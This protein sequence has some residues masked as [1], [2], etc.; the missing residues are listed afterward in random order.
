VVGLLLAL[1]APALGQERK[2]LPE[3]AFGPKP[4]RNPD[5]T[6]SVNKFLS[7]T[8][9]DLQG[10]GIYSRYNF[11]DIKRPYDGLDV[12]SELKLSYWVDRRR[13]VGPFFSLLPSYTT[14]DEFPWQ[15]YVQVGGGAQWYPFAK[16]DRKDENPYLQAVRL[17][18]LGGYR[19]FYDESSRF[20]PQTNS[21][22]QVG[23]DYYYDNL[24]TA[25]PVTISV[26]TNA[27]YRHTNFSFSGYESFL[28]TGNAKVGPKF[29]LGSSF[30]IPYALVDWT[31]VPQ[32]E[33]RFWENFL[34]LGGGVRWYPKTNL[35]TGNKFVD[36]LINRFHV[37]LEVQN[38]VAWLGDDPKRV[39]KD[40]DFRFGISFSTQGFFRDP[41]AR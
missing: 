36:G 39:V 17:F 8:Q 25:Q 27:G 30:V 11:T 31:W 29:Q 2:S 40:T 12:W 21:D 15:R 6:S 37:F 33:G 16:D 10:A 41:A 4:P 20:R 38:N 19:S 35:N 18:V 22:V 23:L 7:Q 34:R 28:W 26:W 24:F 5:E 32:R 3:E 14:E 13:S 1:S 9:I